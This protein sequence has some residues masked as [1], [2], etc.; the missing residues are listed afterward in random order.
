MRHLLFLTTIA[1]CWA[2]DPY[3]TW[4]PNQTVWREQQNKIVTI[5]GDIRRDTFET[6]PALVAPTYAPVLRIDYTH[7]I[8]EWP[9]ESPFPASMDRPGERVNERRDEAMLIF[10]Q[11]L[12]Q[13]G[14]LEIKE[15]G[16]KDDRTDDYHW[17]DPETNFV[18]Y[19]PPWRYGGL[20][21][22][23]GA[24]HPIGDSKD[25][26]LSHGDL[27]HSSW[28]GNLGVRGGV[29]IWL[30]VLT[31]NAR[32]DYTPR[33]INQIDADGKDQQKFANDFFRY[34]G[35]AALTLRPFT[36]GK[37][38]IEQEYEG[39]RWR[40]HSGDSTQFQDFKIMRAPTIGM[41]EIT[42]IS[43]IHLS[44]GAG[45]DWT[46]DHNNGKVFKAGITINF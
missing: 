7:S 21:V 36:W 29:G 30:C 11:K 43:G 12:G 25:W 28:T 9:K 24:Q 6:A 27:S 37:I 15:S 22:E 2:A 42:P 45:L 33:G 39:M 20:A 3:Q 40:W 8:V 35:S 18:F 5:Y 44:G 13:W 23:L 31:L 4:P 38:G 34:Q 1:T 16:S 19:L 26:L 10:R 41:V 17:G 14:A 46:M 32:C